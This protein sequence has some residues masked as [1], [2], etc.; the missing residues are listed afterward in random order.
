MCAYGKSCELC[1]LATTL[2]KV[3]NGGSDRVMLAHYRMRYFFQKRA[4]LRLSLPES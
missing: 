3:A 2:A 4:A 1:P